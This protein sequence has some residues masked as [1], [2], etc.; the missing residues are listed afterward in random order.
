MGLVEPILY[1]LLLA[2]LFLLV[3]APLAALAQV[4]GLVSID[5]WI[6]GVYMATGIHQWVHVC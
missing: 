1:F 4:A 2:L 6:C 3:L 5:P